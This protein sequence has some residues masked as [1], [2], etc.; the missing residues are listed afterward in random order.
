MSR[1]VAATLSPRSSAAIAHSRPNPR[2]VPV[3]NHVCVMSFT[4]RLLLSWS[5]GRGLGLTE[6]LRRRSRFRHACDKRAR[7]ARSDERYASAGYTLRGMP[8]RLR[9]SGALLAV[10]AAL[11]LASCTSAEPSSPAQT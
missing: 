2:D 4:L 8:R 10:P 7:T 5:A 1:A 6:R 9:L 11:L 3:M